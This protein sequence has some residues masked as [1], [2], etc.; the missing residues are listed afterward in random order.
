[1]RELTRQL[2]HLSGLLFVILAQYT[3]RLPAIVM[4]VFLAGTF[5]YY[6]EFVRRQHRT[7]A[8]L[9]Q[10]EERV[11]SVALK[12]ERPKVRRPFLGAIWFY[13]GC[14]VAFIL[15]P[16]PIASLACAV[17]AVGD[18]LSTLVGYHLGRI[19][20]AGEKTLEGTLAFFLS[21]VF[22]LMLFLTPTVALGAAFVAT[23]A[24]LLPALPVFRRLTATGWL[25]DNWL[26]PVLTG[27]FLFASTFWLMPINP[28]FI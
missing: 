1:M 9:K 23:I 5:F 27:A 2:V 17:L 19:K 8:V 16:L 26:I 21:A 11:R 24:E 13:T 15:F 4:F 7:I 12:L 28:T 25:D 3:G 6:S 20:I 14:A 22:V 18:S 10:L